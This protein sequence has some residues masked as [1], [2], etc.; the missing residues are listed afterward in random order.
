GSRLYHP[1]SLVIHNGDVS[2]AQGV[3][4]QWDQFFEQ[5]GAACTGMPMLASVGN[6]EDSWGRS[7]LYRAGDSGGECGVPYRRR[8]DPTWAPAGEGERPRYRSV[9][10]GPMRLIVLDTER[11][12][13]ADS[14]QRL[15]LRAELAEVDRS[16]T[17]WLAVVMHRPMYVNTR[18]NAFPQGK[19]TT[20]VA[21]QTALEDL[22]LEAR[23]DLVLAGHQHSYERTCAVARGRC[24]KQGEHGIVHLGF[25]NGG[26]GLYANPA[27]V[28]PAWSAAYFGTTHGHVRMHV[29]ATTLALE[30]VASKDFGVFDRVSLSRAAGDPRAEQERLR[31]KE[32]AFPGNGPAKRR[33]TWS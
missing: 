6:H 9:E 32:F 5:Q 1:Y 17:P 21:L 10:W 27:K 12:T 23:V 29:N 18:D 16:R 25:G 30:A 3:G 33:H 8:L 20:A 24:V 31:C 13:L 15:W 2:Y 22:M 28:V 11:S 14:A 26:A 7:P 19:L 4:V